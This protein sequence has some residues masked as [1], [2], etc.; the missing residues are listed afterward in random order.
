MQIKIRILE[1]Q[2]GYETQPKCI[3]LFWS[4]NET[5]ELQTLTQQ[6]H[7]KY[8]DL[9]ELYTWLLDPLPSLQHLHQQHSQEPKQRPRAPNL[10]T[11]TRV[12]IVLLPELN[13]LTYA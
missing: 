11:H 13:L 12:H 9:H 8:D 3:I 1:T 4:G 5:R 7:N 2:N 10:Y 6:H